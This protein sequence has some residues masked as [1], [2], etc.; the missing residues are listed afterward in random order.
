MYLPR[1][2][3]WEKLQAQYV[4]LQALKSEPDHISEHATDI[5]GE[6]EEENGQLKVTITSLNDEITCLKAEVKSLED[7]VKEF[8]KAPAYES[9]DRVE[10]NSSTTDQRSVGP[11]SLNPT[12]TSSPTPTTGS[13]YGK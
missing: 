8:Q 5:D 11:L 9:Q 12:H 2:S 3:E 13:V 4:T 10:V 1:L 6:K 7:T